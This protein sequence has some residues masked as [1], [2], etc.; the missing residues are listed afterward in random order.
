[1]SEVH[2]LCRNRERERERGSGFRVAK[3]RSLK[4]GTG[5]TGRVVGTAFYGGEAPSRCSVRGGERGWGEGVDGGEELVC[6]RDVQILSVR[7]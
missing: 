7:G 4:Q 1:M 5:N 3:G 2:E 6:C